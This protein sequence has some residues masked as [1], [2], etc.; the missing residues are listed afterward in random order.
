MDQSA[1]RESV[2]LARSALTQSK[3]VR[4]NLTGDY[5]GHRLALRCPG[6]IPSGK[7]ADHDDRRPGQ[8]GKTEIVQQFGPSQFVGSDPA[9][10]LW[11]MPAGPLLESPSVTPGSDGSPRMM[12]GGRRS[13][14]CRGMTRCNFRTR[15]SARSFFSPSRLRRGRAAAR[16]VQRAISGAAPSAAPLA[17]TRRCQWGI[18]R[19]GVCASGKAFRVAPPRLTCRVEIDDPSS[20]VSLPRQRCRGVPARRRSSSRSSNHRGKAGST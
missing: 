8:C 2:S 4:A 9:D 14:D 11:H 1:D 10:F 5:S 3:P 16:P 7:V 17:V 18:R 13:G 19:R 15:Q 6:G 12:C 20:V